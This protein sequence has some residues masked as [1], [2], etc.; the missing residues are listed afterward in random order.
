M[1]IGNLRGLSNRTIA[2]PPKAESES[3]CIMACRESCTQDSYLDTDAL[4]YCFMKCLVQ[5]SLAQ[6][7]NK[8]QN[9]S[10]P[11]KKD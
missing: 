5:G 8:A 11:P 1:E 7:N 4:N 3:A 9:P 10:E 6:T 2:D